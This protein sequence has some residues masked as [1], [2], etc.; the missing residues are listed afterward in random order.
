MW[1]MCERK[2]QPIKSEQS[3][4]ALFSFSR[5]PILPSDLNL[6]PERG[7]IQWWKI[8]GLSVA[9]DVNQAHRRVQGSNARA[10]QRA[11]APESIWVMLQAFASCMM[12]K[13]YALMYESVY[14]GRVG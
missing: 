12:L 3:P 8:L 9:D 2:S 13:A 11:R 4:A 5:T 7:L 6:P 1:F 14:V 10:K